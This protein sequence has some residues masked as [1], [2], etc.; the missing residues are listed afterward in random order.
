MAYRARNQR[1]TQYD[2]MEAQGHFSSNP[3]NVD[4]VGED[5]EQL[6]KGPVAYPKMM[7]HPEG[8]TRVTVQSEVIVTPFGPK[9]VGEQ[10]EVIWQLA[11]T[12]ADERKLREV[13]WHDHPAKAMAADPQFT[14]VVPPISSAQRIDDLEAQLAAATAALEAAQNP[15]AIASV[16]AA[17][18]SPR[19]L[20][21]EILAKTD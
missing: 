4:A 1:F 10:R 14:G 7:Y 18:G 11:A 2:M 12:A 16:I 13:G 21:T 20:P 15:P 8:K 19:K 17:A 6:Y 9:E 3:A 5:G